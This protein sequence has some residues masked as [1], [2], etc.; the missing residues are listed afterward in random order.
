L[1][2]PLVHISFKYRPNWRPVPAKGI[3]SIGQFGIG[4]I[5]I[6]QFGIGILSL[7]QI[8]VAFYAL[9]QIAVAY[10]LIAQVGLY[11]NQ[12]Y[13][14]HVWDI[15]DSFVS[16]KLDPSSQYTY[17]PP[18]KLDD[19]FE[20]GSIDDVNIDSALIEKAV[21]RIR[22]GRYRGVHSMLIYKD[23]RLVFE[24]YFEGH[25]WKW[26][27]PKHHG[28][29]VTWDRDMLHN[30]HSATKSVTSALI[31]IAIDE[32]FIESVDQSIF[33]YL[34]E[35]Q[36]LKIVGKD[37]ITIEHLL[38]MTSGLQWREWSA[39]Y[40]SS[41]NPAV[42]IW[43]QDKDPI[44]YLL[45]KPLINEPGT[46]FTYS[47][48]NM[49][50][51][52]EII[53]HASNMTIDEFSEEYLFEP[54]KINSTNW[55]LKF[56]NGV[57]GNNLE[58]TP[59]GMTKIGVTFLNKGVWNGKQVISEQW[60]EKCATAFPGNRGID[61]PDEPSGKVGYSYTWWIKEYSHSGK[62]INM[63]AASGFGGQHI[64]VFPELNA[65]VVFTGGNFV[66]SRPPF[67]LLEEYVLPAFG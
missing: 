58:I 31:G 53:R 51:L 7:S 49:Y 18:E 27:A 56:K 9:A 43:F 10:S 57:D 37:K 52:G 65:V 39:P 61:V 46:S 13:G 38:T 1:G 41:D 45:E 20:V 4:L 47:T 55:T 62:K 25:K 24:E 34:P 50:V 8:T 48:G 19:G 54:L 23:N 35:H 40:S 3:I 22:C 33:D 60:I 59:R 26:D 67:I 14:P 29:L 16:C 17:H 2:I 36:H 6:S 21:N 44:T 32:G 63:Y 28:E 42:G 5:N 11:I 64:M 66:T 30:I 15:N 12:G